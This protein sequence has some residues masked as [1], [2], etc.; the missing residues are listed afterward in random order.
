M[1][2]PRAN[3]SSYDVFL[4]FRGEDT[5]HSFT[6]HLYAA[7]KQAGIKTFRDSDDS[8][9]GEELKQEIHR[10]IKASDA[11]IIVLSENYATSTWCLDE[12]SL[13]LDRRRD[14]HHFVLPIFYKVD[15]SDVGQQKGTFSIE[16]N[17]NSFSRRWTDDNVNRWKAALTEVVGIAGMCLVGSET[18]FLKEVVGTIYNRLDRKQIY[19]PPNIIGMDAREKEIKSWINQSESKYLV[20]YGMAGSGKSTLA[21]YIVYLNFQRFESVSIVEHIGRKC[22]E[23]HDMVKLQEQLCTDMLR[24]KDRRIPSVCQGT[25]TIEVLLEQTKALIVL[26]DIVKESQLEDLLGSG[27][28]NKE[29]K[30]IV[31]TDNDISNWFELKSRSCEEYKM[32]L[33]NDE[34]SL[35]L[36]SLHAFR[37]KTPRDGFKELAKRVVEYCEGS[38]LALEVLGSSLSKDNSIRSWES[39][40]NLFGKDFHSDIFGVLKRSYDSLPYDSEKELFLHIACFFVGKD[41]DYIVKILE[42]EYSAESKIKTL[43]KRCFLYVMP[44]KQLMM[45]RLLQ[46]MGRS[47][48]DRESRIFAERSRLWRNKDS[49]DMLRRGKSSDLLKGLTLDMHMLMEEDE[50]NSKQ[51]KESPLTTDSLQRMDQLKLLQLNFVKLTGS[52]KDSSHRLLWLCWFGYNKSIIDSDIFMGNMVA[53]DLSYSRLKEF[54]PPTVLQS[55][56]I[57]NFKDSCYLLEIRNIHLIPNLEALILWNCPR[58]LRVCKT[59]GSLEKLALLNMTGCENLYNKERLNSLVELKATTSGGEST[60]DLSFPLP[61]SLQRLFLKNCKLECTDYFPLSFSDQSSLQYLN[62]GNSL[63]EELPCYIH[64]K[65]LRVLDLSLCSRL[66]CLLCLPSTLAELY[67]YYC[68]SI[69][70]ITFES[71]RFTLQEFGYEGC[72]NLSEI[73]GLLRLVLIVKLDEIDLGHLMWLKEYENHDVCLV[74]DDGLTKDRSCRLQMLYEFNIMSTSLPDIKHPNLTPEYAAQYTCLSFDVPL[75]PRSRS[76]K[77]LNITFRYRISGEDWAWFCKISITSVGDLIYNPKV[78]GKPASG[79]VGVWLSYW[80]IGNL[81]D[82]GDEVEVS[83]VVMSGLEV[84]EC[85]ARLVYTDDDVTG[86]IVENKMGWV[87]TLGGDLSRFQLITGAYYLCRRD[88]FEQT[89][90]GRLTP[91]W[92]SILVGDYID[93]T[94]VRGWRM[95]GRP[96]QLYQSFTELKSISC[97]M[98]G[99]EMILTTSTYSCSITA[100]PEGNATL[101]DIFL[102]FSIK[103]IHDST[104]MDH[105]YDTL[106][107]AQFITFRDYEVNKGELTPEIESVIKKSRSSIVVL[108]KNYLTSPCC[109]DELQLIIEQ[110]RE[111][112]HYVLPIFFHIE[113]S[114][115]RKQSETLEAQ[116]N[117]S[118][119]FT[120]VSVN[121][122]KTALTKVADLAG[123]V[124]SSDRSETEFLEVVVDTIYNTLDRGQLFLSPNLMGIDAQVKEILSRLM[125]S[126]EEFIVICGMGG[127]GKSML[128]KYIIHSNWQ[129]FQSISFIEDIGSRCKDPFDLLEL[130]KQLCRD[131]LGGKNRKISSVY[132]L[133]KIEEVLETRKALVVLD[134]I[135]EPKHLETLIGTGNINKQSKIVITTRENSICKWIE[136][137]SWRCQE[138][139]IKLLSDSV[140]LELLSH[141]A[142]RSKL[143]LDGYEKLANQIVDYCEGNPLALKVLG[144]SLSGHSISHWEN[145][146]D[147]WKRAIHSGIQDVLVRS[148]NS[149]PYDSVKDL[150]LHIACFFIG[151]DVDYV[152]KI[153]EHDYSAVSGFNI[154]I[155]KHLLSVSLNKKLRMHR[156]HQEMGRNIVYQESP[157][158]PSKR[159]RVWRDIESYD[160]LRKQMGSKTIEGLAF[161]MTKLSQEDARIAFKSSE[162][163]TDSLEQMDNLRFLRL[164]CVE[165]VGS[166][167]NFSKE[168]RWLCWIGFHLRAIPSELYMGN[169]VALDMSYSKLV[170]FEPPMV[171]RSLQ[172]LNLKDSHNLLEISDIYLI[173]NLETLILRNC[174]RLIHVC[175]TLGDL[176]N[177]SLLNMT[178]CV[179]L[180]DVSLP[181][182]LERV[183]LKDCNLESTDYG[184]LSFSDQSFLTYLNLANNL[185]ELLPRYSHL[186]Y[187]RV[188]DLTLCSRL[189][190]LLSL[191]STLAE[192]YVNYCESL[193]KVTFESQRFTL[194]K[195]GYEG[196]ISLSEIEDFIKLV[197]VVKLDETD[198]GHMKWLKE[199]QNHEV[200]LIGVAEL[201]NKKNQCLQVLYEFGI[202]STSLPE[203]KDPNM[204]P[205]YVS[206]SPSLSFSVPS[207]PG[208]KRIKGLNVSFKYTISGD[209]CAWFAKISTNNGVDLMYNPK[210]FGKPGFREVGIWLSY[211]PMKT[212]DI[213]DIVSVSIVVM[214]GL[215]VIECGATLVY[216]D[217]LADETLENRLGWVETVGGDLS[218]FQLS[219]GAYYLCRQDFFELVEVGILTSDWFKLL[220]ADK[221]ND[222]E[223]QGWT[224]TGRPK[225]TS[226]PFTELG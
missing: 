31:T 208:N 65:N 115:V 195:F 133:R 176:N 199:Y 19:I 191:P 6:D 75:C 58:L 158:D 32:K 196:C 127:S 77:G 222:T 144:C 194:Q 97:I 166:Y 112:N 9:R 163:R 125:Q 42:P 190:R 162:F 172:I 52:Y 145:T 36:L 159:S 106:V 201:T 86:G 90:V 148:Y 108:S 30:I 154:L 2:L 178:G 33:L 177:L 80:P 174:H 209:D 147:S 17:L 101:Y 175:E 188:L 138:Y 14:C 100:S 56:R 120:D 192:L 37:S 89:E 169:M 84:L 168:L 87:E 197:P 118:P 149:L 43:I 215:D 78:F 67:V 72:I 186:T 167:K 93:S 4:S 3:G 182:S 39:A 187:L 111:R 45:H 173:P 99:P 27:N 223:V 131:I 141:H 207:C 217:D 55:L 68:K 76:L 136:S 110:M 152:V 165:L 132:H 38:P 71:G 29:S 170:V 66:K 134:D 47:L 18:D 128:A 156:L 180:W 59:I 51:L 83:I 160:L 16:A 35:E 139:K 210:V 74:G 13:I 41:M 135:V 98:Y 1:T 107:G 219:S 26:D 130:R 28:I 117:L 164:N 5:R 153:L 8:E 95:T 205:D 140:S 21:Q 105:L 119:R 200:C 116:L 103:D 85:G 214:S 202:L 150:F 94:E 126:D 96:Q 161:D 198:L 181:R 64:L 157:E 92:F 40:L 12:L 11:S 10:A 49:Y 54:E 155:N 57:L 63:F 226:P 123:L 50:F 24:G 23:P 61:H 22:K 104:L 146:L 88:F 184:S 220:V 122:W 113:P 46:E 121:V 70:K 79:E 189:K 81:L 109:L 151:Q 183:F 143:P 25:P 142:F 171:L 203:I 48:V 62:L 185:F 82:I 114:Y 179:S 20:I 193:E 124:L 102:S 225:K 7:L 129:S 137:M 15:P 53:L 34:E 91:G 213:G 73:E 44:N 204:M 206:E 60:Q 69:E 211:W 212:L 224:M 216:T 221:V 218:E